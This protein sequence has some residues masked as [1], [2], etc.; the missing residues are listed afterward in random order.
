MAKK[1]VTG[2]DLLRIFAGSLEQKIRIVNIPAET[3]K[4]IAVT[5]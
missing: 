3:E 1:D 5:K 4:T 2:N